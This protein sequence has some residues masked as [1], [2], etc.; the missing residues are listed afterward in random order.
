M[1]MQ[2]KDIYKKLED[3][4]LSFKLNNNIPNPTCCPSNKNCVIFSTPNLNCDKNDGIYLYNFVTNEIN[5]IHKHTK[6]SKLLLWK[7][8][9]FCFCNSPHLTS[10]GT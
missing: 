10:D 5:L 4:P 7:Q 9:I 3:V 2:T 6:D 8:W 1:A